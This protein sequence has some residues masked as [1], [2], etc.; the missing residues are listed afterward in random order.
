MLHTAKIWEA[1]MIVMG[2]HGRPALSRVG[3]GSVA[4]RVVRLSPVPVLVVSESEA[5]KEDHAADDAELPT[6]SAPRA[7]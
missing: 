4:E 3:L 7:P 2:R 1:D 6:A 5:R